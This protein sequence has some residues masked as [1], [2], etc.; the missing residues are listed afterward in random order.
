MLLI[1][2]EPSVRSINV[3]FLYLLLKMAENKLLFSVMHSGLG[4]LIAE[5]APF[6]K[7]GWRAQGYQGSFRKDAFLRHCP[8]S[9]RDGG[10]LQVG[11]RCRRW[12]LT[13]G[14]SQPGPRNPFP[15][16]LCHKQYTFASRLHAVGHVRCT[17]GWHGEPGSLVPW[18]EEE[19]TQTLGSQ[20]LTGVS[21]ILNT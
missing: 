17:S 2:P 13:S 8:H 9:S 16:L 10:I 11:A 4:Q 12:T 5:V 21:C 14:D 15:S 7:N 1:A 20:H 19:G 6:F 3:A 18:D